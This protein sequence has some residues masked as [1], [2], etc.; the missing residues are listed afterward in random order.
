MQ[1]EARVSTQQQVLDAMLARLA[2]MQ[3]DAA[4][5]ASET[6]TQLHEMRKEKLKLRAVRK[7]GKLQGL[8]ED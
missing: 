7:D 1:A 2:D 3:A 5:R 8:Q 6:Q 4:R